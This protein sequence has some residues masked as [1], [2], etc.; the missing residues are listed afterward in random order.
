MTPWL[1]RL[2]AR[3]RA[4]FSRL[5]LSVSCPRAS[6]R[7]WMTVTHLG[8]ARASI[9]LCLASLLLPMVSVSAAWETLLL[10]GLSHVLI[11]V[12]KRTIGRPRP[13]ASAVGYCHIDAPDHFS[14]PSGHSCAA[15]AVA[16][17]FAHAFPLLSIPLLALA[18]V[19]GFSRVALGVHYPG[20]VLAGQVI[21]LITAYLLFL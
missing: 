20:D 13:A 9:G 12:V 5:V 17:G 4:L 21:A 10:L 16:L 2:D 1:T 15:M 7:A 19:V 3:D 18:C 14:F 6:R 8:G 11:Q